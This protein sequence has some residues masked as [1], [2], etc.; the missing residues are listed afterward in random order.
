MSEFEARKALAREKEAL[1][2]QF[3]AVEEAGATHRRIEAAYNE[4]MDGVFDC[5]PTIAEA[6]EVVELKVAS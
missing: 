2:S 4:R 5:P 6:A 3:K 1:I